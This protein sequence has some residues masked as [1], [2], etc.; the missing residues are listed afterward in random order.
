[1]GAEG[2]FD[3]K[4]APGYDPESAAT[5]PSPKPISS[6]VSGPASSTV[7]PSAT[8]AASGVTTTTTSSSSSS[9]SSSSQQQ[10]WSSLVKNNC[11][12]KGGA[13]SLGGASSSSRK[14]SSSS[15]CSV[16]SSSD[17]SLS[18]SAGLPGTGGLRLERRAEGLLLDQGSGVGGVTGVGPEGHQHEPIV[19]LS[20]AAEGGS[21]SVS[22]S[23]TLT[24]DTPAPG[25]EARNKD[26]SVATDPAT[27]IS[28][29]LV[30]VSSPDVSSVSESSSKDTPSQRPLCSAANARLSV[31]SLLAAG[32]P[33]SSSASV[34]NLSSREASLMESFVRRAP[35]MSRT[36]ATNNMNLSRSSSDNNTNTLG[37]NVMSTATSPLMGAQSFPNLTTTGTT[38]TVT[39]STSIVTSSNNV[40]T[41]TTGL[42]VGQLLS[43]TLTTSL[44]STSSESDTGQE[45]EFSLYDFLD[46]CRAN[47]LL[48]ELDDEEDLPEPDD[49]DDENEDD[50]Q[51]DQEYEEVLEEEEYETKGGR[52]RTWDDDFVL[53]RQFSALV[54]A[55]D[56][57]PGRTNVQQT[58]DL[59]IPPPGTPRSEVQEEVECAPSPHLSL[60]LK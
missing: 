17:I 46:S 5:A 27:A 44:T 7:G 30:S 52:R 35:N 59:E 58:T 12:D 42:S 38:S 53:K 50:N 10:S 6:T 20:S 56:P 57:R 8:P 41:A 14:G 1:M 15:V 24:A 45:A 28:M 2:K 19:V 39:M 31:S 36:N 51:E 18:S 48:A 13:A 21:G 43:N 60:T 4:L 40:A 29:G 23:G 37:R 32:A 16:A 54:P 26:S 49:D 22:S 47:T 55:F 3:L 25:D 9:T 33:M 34:P 11:P